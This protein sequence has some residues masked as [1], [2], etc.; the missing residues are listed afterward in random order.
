MTNQSEVQRIV[1]ES[2]NSFHC[3]VTNHLAEKGW[4][5]LISPYYMDAAANKPREVDLIAEKHWI[6]KDRSEGKYG[7]VVIR[8]FIECKYI[9]QPNVFWFA[10][11]D[12][13][14]ATEWLISNTPLRKDNMF[15]ERHHYLSASTNVAKLFASKNLPNTENEPIYRALNQ[16][17][18]SMVYL[19][20]HESLDEDI[21]IGRLPILSEMEMPVI[22]CNSFDQFYGIDMNSIGPPARI[23][24]SFQLEVNYAYVDRAARQRSEYF[25]L[26]VVNFNRIDEYLEMIEND[27]SAIFH[28]L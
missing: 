12:T 16:A 13:S 18:N 1:D 20:G 9:P 24:E 10:P 8:F 28:I 11:R 19:R 15:T 27:V 23:D 4:S 25:L 5:T 17:L 26:D 6:Y 2:G 22:V 14:A 3:R 21:R 7:A